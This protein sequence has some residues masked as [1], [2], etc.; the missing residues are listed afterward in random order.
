MVADMLLQHEEEFKVWRE[1]CLREMKNKDVLVWIG[2]EEKIGIKKVKAADAWKRE[3]DGTK[4]LG[5]E[6]PV[7][8]LLSKDVPETGSASSA[9]FS[10]CS[11]AKKEGQN[12]TLV[13]DP[14]AFLGRIHLKPKGQFF[15][16]EFW[17]DRFLVFFYNEFLPRK[18]QLDRGR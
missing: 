5:S 18:D 12:E 2:S 7:W 4:S 15:E 9:Y 3:R 8:S 14:P 13:F 1:M 11:S 16:K 6:S 17:Y 10:Q